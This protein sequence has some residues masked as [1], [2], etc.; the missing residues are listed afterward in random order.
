MIQSELTDVRAI[1][2]SI[3]AAGTG[4]YKFIQTDKFEQQRTDVVLG[5][6]I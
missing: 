6:F 1:G 5:L 4:P 3:A 2:N